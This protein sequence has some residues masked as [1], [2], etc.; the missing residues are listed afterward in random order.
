MN[1][2]SITFDDVFLYWLQVETNQIEGRDILSVAKQKGFNTIAEWRLM[3]AKRL[4]LDTKEWQEEIISD[5]EITIP[6]IIVGPYQG[7]QRS[8]CYRE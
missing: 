6:K 4:G 3:T 7:E 5:P 2:K 1:T 8:S